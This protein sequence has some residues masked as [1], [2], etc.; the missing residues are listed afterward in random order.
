MSEGSGKSEEG[1]E[2]EEERRKSGVAEESGA[3]KRSLAAAA[4]EERKISVYCPPQDLAPAS[5]PAG[6]SPEQ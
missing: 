5:S 3:G 4:G 2:G 6:R 1:G